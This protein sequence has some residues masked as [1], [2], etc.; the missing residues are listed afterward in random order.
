MCVFFLFL[1]FLYD[2]VDFCLDYEQLCWKS[3]L[4]SLSHV[5]VPVGV[6]IL[7]SITGKKILAINLSL[8]QK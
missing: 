2:C 6:V 4:I 1:K 3:N 5:Q 7:L 8:D